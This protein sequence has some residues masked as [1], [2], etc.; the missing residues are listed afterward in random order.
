MSLVPGDRPAEGDVWFRIITSTDHITKGRVH[1][2]AFRKKNFFRPP[3]PEHSRPWTAESSGRLRSLAGS[4]EDIAKHGD[5]YAV[6][7][8]THF[9]GVMYPSKPICLKVIGNLTL[10]VCYTPIND[11]DQAHADLTATGE[12][13]ADRTPEH[14]ELLHELVDSFKALYAAQIEHLPPVQE[15]LLVSATES[16]PPAPPPGIVESFWQLCRALFFWKK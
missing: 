9:I 4:I 10:D 1:H 7:N 15:P 8:R 12:L 6:D 2:S 16:V 11:G 5:Q 13:P 14:E 3:L